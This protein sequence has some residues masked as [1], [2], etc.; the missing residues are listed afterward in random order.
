M[1]S[2]VNRM[3]IY[4]IEYFRYF[5]ILE[6][7]NSSFIIVVILLLHLTATSFAQ[8]SCTDQLIWRTMG[9]NV[10]VNG[11]RFHIFYRII[12]DSL[13]LIGQPLVMKGVSWF[14]FETET[15]A[16]HGLWSQSLNSMLD[17]VK[18]NNFNAIRLPFS[19]EMV[20]TNPAH[21]NVDCNANADICQMNALDL[22]NAVID[23]YNNCFHNI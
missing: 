9:R 8:I 7:M 14:G 18:N 23:R 12:I 2:N 10:L 4:I 5:Q 6:T 15:F 16:P 19:M 21:T 17:F 22:M 3:F 1:S 11:N 20:R 13:S